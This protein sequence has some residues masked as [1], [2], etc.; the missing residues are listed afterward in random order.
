[1]ILEIKKAVA[2]I[3]SAVASPIKVAF[4]TVA[5]VSFSW[6]YVITSFSLSAIAVITGVKASKAWALKLVHAAVK[7]SI[8]VA[9]SLCD[10]INAK[11]AAFAS[12]ILELLSAYALAL[13]P[14]NLLRVST[15]N[16]CLSCSLLQAASFSLN[17][18][19]DSPA[20]L[21]A[22]AIWPVSCPVL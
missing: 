20:Q 1:M 15:T 22:S 8:A 11:L 17:S 5:A 12:K 16:C 3:P 14:Y 18:S 4:K 2:T 10:C 19:S 21:I 7:G 6:K 9:I 13:S